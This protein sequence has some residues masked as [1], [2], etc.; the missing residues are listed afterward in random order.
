M[1]AKVY[2]FGLSGLICAIVSFCI[3]LL[4]SVRVTSFL[5]TVVAITFIASVVLC[6]LAL[7]LYKAKRNIDSDNLGRRFAIIGL[8]IL[9]LEIILVFVF[10][11]L[12]VNALLSCYSHSDEIINGISKFMQNI[13]R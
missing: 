3:T 5:E 12:A 10:V 7:C 8:I 1:K 13:P 11:M 6:I 2:A 4:M 9:S